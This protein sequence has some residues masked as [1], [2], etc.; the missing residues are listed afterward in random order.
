MFA[1]DVAEVLFAVVM[2][3]VVLF[4][5]VLFV[6]VLFAVVLPPTIMYAGSGCDA[7]TPGIE[8][9]PPP[10]VVLFNMIYA[11]SGCDAGTPGIDG[12]PPPYSAFSALIFA[13][14]KVDVSSCDTDMLVGVVGWFCVLAQPEANIMTTS[15][16]IVRI[17]IFIFIPLYFNYT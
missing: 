8:A 9:V 15:K 5:V 13:D 3:V 14:C 16:S 1:V 7:G 11:G 4:A 12:V 6:V 10:Y 17:C 2:F